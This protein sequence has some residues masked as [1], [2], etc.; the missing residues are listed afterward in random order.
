MAEPTQIVFSHTEVVQAL[1]K[2]QQI[3]EGIWGI[4]IKFGIKAANVGMSPSDLLPAAIVPVIEIGLQKF[5]EE[6]NLAV[7]AAKVNPA[8]SSRPKKAGVAKAK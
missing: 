7:D 2:Q 4:Y 1:L 5:D 3:H 6:N 8:A